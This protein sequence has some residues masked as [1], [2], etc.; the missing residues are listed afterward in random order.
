MV[1]CWRYKGVV[2]LVVGDGLDSV[3]VVAV[4]EFGSI[5]LVEAAGQG[6]LS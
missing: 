2:S 6:Y 3:C 1:W 5:L 4:V